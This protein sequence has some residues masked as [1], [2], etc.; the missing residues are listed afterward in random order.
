MRIYAM[1]I[2]HQPLHYPTILRYI[3][4]MSD[5]ADIS[6]T[7]RIGKCVRMAIPS[8]NTMLWIR[9]L[10]LSPQ[11]AFLPSAILKELSSTE[12]GFSHITHFPPV[13]SNAETLARLVPGLCECGIFDGG[14]KRGFWQGAG[15]SLQLGR[16]QVFFCVILNIV[17]NLDFQG[18]GKDSVIRLARWGDF[19]KKFWQNRPQY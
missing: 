2:P 7:M 19:V 8:I 9:F 15:S 17:K 1:R 16:K 3:R 5:N 11:P 18:A 12:K 14:E 6:A 4:H 10:S 13:S